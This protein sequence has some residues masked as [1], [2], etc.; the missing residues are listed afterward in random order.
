MDTYLWE[1]FFGGGETEGYAIFGNASL[2][3]AEGRRGVVWGINATIGQRATGV[4]TALFD[5]PIENA[6]GIVENWE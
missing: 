6:L 4:G 2:S 5:C 3:A 1:F